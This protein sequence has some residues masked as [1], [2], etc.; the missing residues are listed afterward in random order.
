M[1]RVGNWLALLGAFVALYAAY[2]WLVAADF[3]AAFYVDWLTD[4]MAGPP[5]MSAQGEFKRA[6]PPVPSLVIRSFLEHSNDLITVGRA[7]MHAAFATAVSA[8]LIAV[9]EAFSVIARWRRG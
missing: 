9:G 6:M 7:N 5:T 8:I 3:A 1:R 4:A 2:L